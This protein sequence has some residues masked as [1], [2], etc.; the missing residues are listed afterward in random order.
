MA[1]SDRS[2]LDAPGALRLRQD[3]IPDGRFGRQVHEKLNIRYITV[4]STASPGGTAA[5]HGVKPVWIGQTP[6]WVDAFFKPEVIPPAVFANFHWVTGMTYWGE[7]VPGMPKFLEAYEK[8]GKQLAPPDFYML[9]SY[10]GGLEGIEIIRRAIEA[11][12]VTREGLLAQIPKLENFDANGLIQPIS[13]AKVPYVT[14]TKT[15]IIKPDFEKKTWSPVA[16]WAT[17]AVLQ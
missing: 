10:V 7:N 15:R 16:D 4:H 13:L 12:D 11:G 1:E 2:T 6:T 8:H 9:M 5:T 17:P 3:L 14:S